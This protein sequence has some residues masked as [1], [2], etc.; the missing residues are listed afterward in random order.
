MTPAAPRPTRLGW[1]AAGIALC[2]CQNTMLTETHVCIHI[3][4]GQAGPGT[5]AS[6]HGNDSNDFQVVLG[7]ANVLVDA[8]VL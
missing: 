1:R 6:G 8:V 5:P 4:V 7:V 2:T 3:H